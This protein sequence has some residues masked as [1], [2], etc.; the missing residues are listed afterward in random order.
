MFEHLFTGLFSYLCHLLPQVTAIFSPVAFHIVMGAVLLCPLATIIVFPWVFLIPLASSCLSA[1][2]GGSAT[3]ASS[4]LLPLLHLGFL[5]MGFSTS[6]P[7]G[8]TRWL[9]CSC[10]SWGGQA[11]EGILDIEKVLR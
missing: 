8:S 9:L 4:L 5:L 1:L 7:F 3:I 10:A 2:F 11:Y 6:A